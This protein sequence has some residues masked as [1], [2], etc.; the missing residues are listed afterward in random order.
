M[1]PLIFVVAV[2]AQ[3]ALLEERQK[4]RVVAD[5]VRYVVRLGEGRYGD[6]RHAEPILIEGRT[7]VR[8]R[9]KRREPG[10][11]RQRVELADGAVGARA[12][13]RVGCVGT[14]A[15]EDPVGR[16]CVAL[17]RARRSHVVV[18]AAVLV[19]GDEHDRVFPVRTASHRPDH[20]RDE[21][22]PGADVARWVLVELHATEAEGRIDE[23]DGR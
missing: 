16:P 19:V 5:G 22:L 12:R 10:T 18:G 7:I 15:R 13:H 14:L 21:E 2:P 8:V 23:G 6:E 11:E 9:T 20:V 17:A 3:E 1:R 4:G